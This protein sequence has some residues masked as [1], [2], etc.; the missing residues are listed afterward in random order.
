MLTTIILDSVESFAPDKSGKDVLFV[1]DWAS[2]GYQTLFGLLSIE[3]KKSLM[4]YNETGQV[5]DANYLMSP[6]SLIDAYKNSVLARLIS[7]I[8]TFNPSKM[9]LA[10]EGGSGNWRYDI[11]P[12]YKGNRKFGEWPFVITKREFDNVRNELAK[13]ISDIFASHAIGV[14][15]AEGDDVIAGAVKLLKDKYDE[16]IISS[17]D[18]DIVQLTIYPNVKVFDSK[19]NSFVSC[20]EGARFFLETKILQGDKSDNIYGVMLPGK[21]RRLGP[22][23]SATLYNSCSGNIY[24]KANDEG[25]L[26]QYLIN[27]SL[28]DMN[29]IPSEIMDAVTEAIEGSTSQ[30]GD[31]MDLVTSGFSKWNIESVSSLK[32]KKINLFESEKNNGVLL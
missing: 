1:V 4:K 3:K 28:I 22:K 26:D 11:Y 27:K 19:I 5:D 30:F 20:E 31:Y 16:I 17:G 10:L 29:Q 8:E 15:R 23:T 6:E 24:D 2:L 14:P 13:E 9:I 12:E 25:W 18:R 32:T 7:Q 21:K